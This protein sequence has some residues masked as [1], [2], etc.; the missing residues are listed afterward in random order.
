M[1]NYIINYLDTD[2]VL[3]QANVSNSLS[4]WF[5]FC[6]IYENRSKKTC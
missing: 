1:V 6:N 4:N 3:F 2:T 5:K